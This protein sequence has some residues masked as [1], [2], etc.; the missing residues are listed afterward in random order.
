VAFGSHRRLRDAAQVVLLC[1]EH[2]I[3]SENKKAADGRGLLSGVF[4]V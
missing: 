1:F 4:S 3:V 2:K